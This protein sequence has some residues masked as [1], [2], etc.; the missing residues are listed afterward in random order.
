MI[1]ADIMP[2]TCG[3]M[4]ACINC[5]HVIGLPFSSRGVS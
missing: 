5:L 4:H 2:V 1:T 3:H